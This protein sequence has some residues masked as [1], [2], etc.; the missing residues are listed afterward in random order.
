MGVCSSLRQD[1]VKG[2][3][4]S[5]ALAHSGWG[6]GGVRM[7]SEPVAAEAGVTLLQP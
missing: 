3:A 6:E 1:G 2:A 7:R 4:E 5:G